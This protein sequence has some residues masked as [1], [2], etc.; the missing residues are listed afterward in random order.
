M[1]AIASGLSPHPPCNPVEFQGPQAYFE[2]PST[3]QPPLG[4]VFA[5]EPLHELDAAMEVEPE[6]DTNFCKIHPCMIVF[7]TNDKAIVGLDLSSEWNFGGASD[8]DVDFN[9]PPVTILSPTTIT[10]QTFSFSAS[11]SPRPQSAVQ[12][13]SPFSQFVNL[14]VI[15]TRPDFQIMTNLPYF[16]LQT[17]LEQPGMITPRFASLFLETKRSFEN[18]SPCRYIL[19]WTGFYCRLRTLLLSCRLRHDEMSYRSYSV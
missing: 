1:A 12:R 11:N 5:E 2:A 16:R 9:L 4:M 7:Q 10:R 18:T 8:F 3:Q 17:M 19:S 13:L 6:I 15:D 14:E